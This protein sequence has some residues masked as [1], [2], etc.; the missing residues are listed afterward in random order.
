MSPITH[1]VR[2]SS[3]RL[4]SFDEKMYIVNKVAHRRDIY[5]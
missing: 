1:R 3:Y 4:L 2:I 5:K